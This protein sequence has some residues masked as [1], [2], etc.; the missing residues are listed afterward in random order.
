M[1]EHTRATKKMYFRAQTRV[2][3]HVHLHYKQTSYAAKN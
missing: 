3:I 1:S 2:H